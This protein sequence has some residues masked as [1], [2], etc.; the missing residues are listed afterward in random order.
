M[1]SKDSLSTSNSGSSFK[2][3]INFFYVP[4]GDDMESIHLHLM[5]LF[6]V[7]CVWCAIRPTSQVSIPSLPT[8]E[9]V[10]R[11]LLERS[12]GKNSRRSTSPS[13]RVLFRPAQSWRLLVST[14]GT[15]IF[16]YISIIGGT[17]EK[18]KLENDK[19]FLINLNFEV[20]GSRI[21]NHGFNILPVGLSFLKTIPF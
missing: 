16:I 3:L 9:N 19:N 8:R 20:C 21:K 14:L 17:F 6:Q 4:I 18:L 10:D 5:Q 2:S 13:N 11:K 12:S 1:S 15:K 7:A